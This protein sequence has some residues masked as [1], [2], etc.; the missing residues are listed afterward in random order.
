VTFP[1]PRPGL[2]LRYR[3]LWVD[4]ATKGR[5]EGDKELSCWRS[6]HRVA[7]HLGYSFCLLRTRRL[8]Q[9]PK[10]LRFPLRFADPMV[11]TQHVHG[12][13]FPSLMN[14]CG[15]GSTWASCRDGNPIRWLT[16]IL[17]PDFSLVSESV[18]W[19]L[20]RPESRRGFRAMD[21]SSAADV[22]TTHMRGRRSI[23]LC[24]VT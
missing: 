8:R 20:M 4:D 14:S 15:R 7:V 13:C 9:G 23:S 1:Q 2:V 16:G 22:A 10:R 17:R 24:Q 5:D 3:Y 19:R 18:G 6:T 11:L 12:L 21:S